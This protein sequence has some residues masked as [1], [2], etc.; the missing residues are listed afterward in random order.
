MRKAY[1]LEK[2]WRWEDESI[3]H[4]LGPYMA[5]LKRVNDAVRNMGKDSPSAFMKPLLDATKKGT[6][7]LFSFFKSFPARSIMNVISTA[8]DDV[9]GCF[10]APS[11]LLFFFYI[12][13][14]LFLS[15][16]FLFFLYL[17]FFFFFFVGIFT[18]E[19]LLSNLLIF[20]YAQAPLHVAF[21]LLYVLAL[22]PEEEK[23]VVAEISDILSKGPLTYDR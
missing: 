15:F 2:E 8:C 7:T 5:K 19:E 14:L 12:F 18:E 20:E 16:I 6:T 11:A 3:N 9:S 23:K 4:T 1:K 17:L 10:S 21:W 13:R 22:H